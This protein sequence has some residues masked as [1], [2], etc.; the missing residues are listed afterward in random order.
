[1]STAAFGNSALTATAVLLVPGTSGSYSTLWLVNASNPNAALTYL[2]FFDAAAISS[3]TLGTTKPA[4]WLAMPINTTGGVVSV[5]F[6]VGYVF[7]NGIVVAATTTPTGSS[8]PSTACP[9]T[10]FVV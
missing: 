6:P 7:K 9:V 2:Q 10:L 3:V 4:F 5:S 1:M 8:A